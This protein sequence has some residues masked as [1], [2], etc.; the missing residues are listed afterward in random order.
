[1][2]E[3]MIL[4][5]DDMTALIGSMIKC[6]DVLDAENYNLQSKF[7]ELQEEFDDAYYNQFATKFKDGDLMVYDLKYAIQDII[8]AIGKYAE[9]LVDMA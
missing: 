3:K 1:M 8:I 6:K 5:V 4:N 7:H 2:E 9:K